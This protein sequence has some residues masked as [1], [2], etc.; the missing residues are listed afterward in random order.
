MV[1]LCLLCALLLLLLLVLEAS[2][3]AVAPVALTLQVAKTQVLV[4]SAVAGRQLGETISCF[5][6]VG[7]SFICVGTS[8][9]PADVSVAWAEDSSLGGSNLS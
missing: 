3:V 1:H 6:C 2:D 8:L 9:Y 7:T 4:V 5:I